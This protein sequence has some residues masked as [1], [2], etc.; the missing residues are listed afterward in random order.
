LISTDFIHTDHGYSKYISN[1]RL[2]SYLNVVYES[3]QGI[4]LLGVMNKVGVYFRYRRNFVEIR[5]QN[6][7]GENG[8][9]MIM[10]HFW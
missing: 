5:T 6:E 3:G 2:S 9:K 1:L 7:D 4:S 8:T 10:K